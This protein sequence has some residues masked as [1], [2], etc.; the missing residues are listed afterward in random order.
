[1]SGTKP[2]ITLKKKL[3]LSRP[4]EK[5]NEKNE[6]KVIDLKLKK[7]AEIPDTYPNKALVEVLNKLVKQIADENKSIAD[8][9]LKKKN[10]FRIKSFYR[11]IMILREHPEK[12]TSGDQAKQLKGIGQGMA[13]R[14]DEIL[15]TGT[16]DE[17]ENGDELGPETKAVD[18]LITISG[19]GEKTA[20]R[21]YRDYGIKGVD[22]L[23]KRWREGTFAVGK[24]KLTH[25]IELGLK[26][27][28]D[29]RVRIPRAEIDEFYPKVVAFAQDLDSDLIAEIAGSYRRKK[30]DSGDIDILLSHPKLKSKTDLE[31]S[32]TNYLA[33][34]VEKLM[35]EGLLIDH[36]DEDFTSYY[37]GVILLDKIPR[38]I[39]VMII[40]NDTFAAA[41]MHNTGSGPFNQRIRA[42]AMMKGYHLSQHGLYKV[43]DG[44]KEDSPIPT[45]SERE[46]FD[47]LGVKYLKPEERD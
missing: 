20:L 32:K 29:F 5:K 15:E 21:F 38:R 9:D 24:H 39:D 12:I 3:T 44:R 41:L 45:K 40:P 7:K 43:V 17:L 1:M 4:A 19:I 36:L 46:I 25:H 37:K 11:A 42:H 2:K 35:D 22:D 14:I 23:L 6:K 30:A 16:L 33:E 13:D 10:Q 18:D 26:Y 28:D 47:I 8:K 27:Y 31:K 34:F